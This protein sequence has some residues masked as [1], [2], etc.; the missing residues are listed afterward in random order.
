MKS[1]VRLTVGIVAIVGSISFVTAAHAA[2]VKLPKT[3]AWTA[4]NTGT[5]G[6]N[7]SVAIGK[8]LKDTYGVSLRVVPAKNDVSRL[9]P[10]V[11]GK[12]QFSAN[13][14][15]TYFGSE[16]V[17]LFAGKEWGPQPIQL[18]MS[19]HADTNLT[20]ATAADA[21]IKAIKDLKGKRVGWIRGGIAIN[22]GTEATLAFGGLTWNDVKKVEFPGYGAMW[23]GMVNNQVDAAFASTASGPTKKLQAS[24][25]G[26]H[27]LRMPH[28]DNKGWKRAKKVAPY[29]MRHTATIGTGLSKDKPLESSSYPYPILV[30]LTSHSDEL[31][32]SMAKAIHTQFDKFKNAEPAAAGWALDRQSFKWSVPY[33]KGAVKYW[34][35]IGAWTKDIEQHNNTLLK[36]QAVLQEAWRAMK[37]KSGDGFKAEWM[38]VRAAALDKAGLDPIWR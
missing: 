34:K 18:V 28:N 8:A 5:T 36:R 38:K 10:L 14:S 16:G 32:Y 15:G 17:F 13:G 11:K 12:V 30:A 1:L 20:L 23:R 19:G 21:N 37:G 33:H 9:R 7:Q 26:I 4:Y 22:M 29:F 27:W 6:Y 35:E 3:L 2:E 31:V 24:P 25:R